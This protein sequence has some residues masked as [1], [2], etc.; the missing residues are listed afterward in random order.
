MCVCV[1]VS[2]VEI[3]GQV[4]LDHYSE[5]RTCNYTLLNHIMMQDRRG[6]PLVTSII[7]SYQIAEKVQIE[8]NFMSGNKS[9]KNL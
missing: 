3:T 9:E 5:L 8:F 6:Y 2:L 7:D 1:C 4:I